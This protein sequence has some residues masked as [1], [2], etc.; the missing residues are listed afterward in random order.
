MGNQLI[1]YYSYEDFKEYKIDSQM[2]VSEINQNL[3]ALRRLWNQREN[4]NPEKARVV[5][6]VL[7]SA[8]KHFANEQAKAEYDRALEQQRRNAEQDK[9]RNYSGDDSNEEK[10][11]FVDYYSEDLGISRAMS[12]Q[13]ILSHLNRLGD[14]L[15]SRGTFNSVVYHKLN[16]IDK[17]QAVFQNEQSK[18]AYDAEIDRRNRKA[19]QKDAEQERKVKLNDCIARARSFLSKGFTGEANAAA[20]TALRYYNE[21]KDGAEI[22]FLFSEIAKAENKKDQAVRYIQKAVV[23]DPDNPSV[24]C[25]SAHLYSSFIHDAGQCRK[26]ANMAIECAEKQGDKY[27]EAIGNGL[28]AWSYYFQ[29]PVAPGKAR[30]LANKAHALLPNGDPWQ[31]AEKVL[32]KEEEKRIQALQERERI[33]REK[34]LEKEKERELAKKYDKQIERG[35]IIGAVIVIAF[36]ALIAFLMSR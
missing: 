1:D 20:E 5:L 36:I 26:Y 12:A 18:Q 34:Q 2:S 23:I 11:D 17:G 24:Y 28:L 27:F 33:E 21:S 35:K 22:Y 29:E 13:E 25:Q 16:L 15:R 8:K 30:L 9:Q 31:N 4:R 3:L 7:D 19:P 6:S 14:Q 32:Q 10:G